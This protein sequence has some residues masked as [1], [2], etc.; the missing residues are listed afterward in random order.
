MMS[1]ILN[2]ENKRIE[3][4]LSLEKLLLSLKLTHPNMAVA[5]NDSVIPKSEYAQKK[6]ENGDR[7][8]I[9]HPVGGG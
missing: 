8:E 2:G 1:V 5:I 4:G 9:I 6:I 3:P 7:I